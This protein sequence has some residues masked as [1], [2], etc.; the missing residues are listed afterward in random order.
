MGG[1]AM[2]RLLAAVAFATL[3]LTGSALADDDDAEGLIGT[4]KLKSFSLRVL[5]EQPKPVFGT[6]PKG[7]MVITPG[8]LVMVIMT[9]SDRKPASDAEGQSAL[10]QSMVAYSGKY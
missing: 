9:R 6:E 10:L 4:W 5:G 1:K 7:H 2:M 8:N 3:L